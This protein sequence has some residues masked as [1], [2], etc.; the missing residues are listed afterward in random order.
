ME[1]TNKAFSRREGI[2]FLF[3]PVFI[4]QFSFVFFV[5]WEHEVK[6]R[7]KRK[8][9]S[10]GNLTLSQKIVE[11][12]YTV[13]PSYWIFS[14]KIHNTEGIDL[15]RSQFYLRKLKLNRCLLFFFFGFK[16]RNQRK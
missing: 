2:F 5:L 14:F 11:F 3:F 15:E 6:G 10:L 9:K 12:S 16:K 13:Y 1:F 4:T 7:E 8:E